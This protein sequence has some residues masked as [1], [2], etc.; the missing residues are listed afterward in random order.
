VFLLGLPGLDGAG[1]RVAEWAGRLRVWMVVV[2]LG[3]AA[4][5][6]L[7]APGLAGLG[8][9]WAEM[10]AAF[11]GGCVAL[12]HVREEPFLFLGFT[13]GANLWF[14][15]PPLVSAA[16]A[17]WV[18]G[19][20]YAAFLAV[21]E[22]ASRRD[23]L[24]Q[25]ALIV[26]LLAGLL[27]FFVPHWLLKGGQAARVLWLLDGRLR[28]ERVAL[29]AAL[30]DLL[31]EYSPCWSRGSSRGSCWRGSGGGRRSTRT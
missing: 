8:G 20:A 9:Q 10:H 24:S 15:A 18:V 3:A 16:A 13:L 14:I 1:G 28:R 22:A 31:P 2:A 7:V 27:V 4:G 29:W 23:G 6:A 19:G 12:A 21:F 25:P 5:L 17:R 11:F 26:G 30:R